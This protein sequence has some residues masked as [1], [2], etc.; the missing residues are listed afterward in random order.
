[1]PKEEEK[2]EEKRISMVDMAAK[3]TAALLTTQEALDRQASRRRTKPKE[4]FMET[5]R[6][7][8]RDLMRAHEQCLYEG[9]WKT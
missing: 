1:M 5:V 2:R 6:V 9:L 7:C 3:S 8:A 4:D